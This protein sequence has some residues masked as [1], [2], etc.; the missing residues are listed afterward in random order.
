M[1]VKAYFENQMTKRR[2]E[3]ISFD[4][5]AGTVTLKGSHSTIEE[6]YDK[7]RLKKMGYKLIKEDVPEDDEPVDDED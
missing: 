1:T 4:K 7:D 5:E 3:I 6:P 2:F